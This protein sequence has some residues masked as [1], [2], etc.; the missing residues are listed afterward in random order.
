LTERSGRQQ[1]GAPGAD[2]ERWQT[3]RDLLFPALKRGCACRKS[4]PD[5][6]VVQSTQDWATKNVPGAIDGARDRSIF[7]QG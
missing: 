1:L 7:L 4:N 5:I 6:L 2:A 3:G